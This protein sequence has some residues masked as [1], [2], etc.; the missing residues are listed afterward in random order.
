[1]RLLNTSKA[2]STKRKKARGNVFVTVTKKEKSELFLF[3][4]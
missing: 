3:F 2:E 1:M 4:L